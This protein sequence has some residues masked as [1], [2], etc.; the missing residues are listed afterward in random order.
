[1][2][3]FF[4]QSHHHSVI[5]REPHDRGS[6]DG[7]LAHKDRTVVSEMVAPLVTPWVKEAGQLASYRIDARNVRPIVFP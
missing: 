4:S 3:N 6:P 7:G 2:D 5:H 1:M